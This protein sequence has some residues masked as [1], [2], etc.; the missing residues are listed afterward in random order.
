M[1]IYGTNGSH[2]R[3]EPLPGTACPA[4]RAPDQMQASLFSR[5]AHIYWIP[6]LP[7]SKPAVAECLH[8]R[9]NWELGELPPEAGAVKEALRARRKATRAPW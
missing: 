4:C 2:V 7:Y 3:T 5:Y 8:C 1:I 9:G 6:L